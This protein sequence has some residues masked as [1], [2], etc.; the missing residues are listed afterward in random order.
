MSFALLYTNIYKL[1]T[2]SR[3]IQRMGLVINR[4]E[5][6]SIIEKLQQT[7]EKISGE[8]KLLPLQQ[9]NEGYSLFQERFNPTKLKALTGEDL[10]ETVINIGNRNGLTYWLE[11]KNDEEFKTNANSYGSIAGGSAFKYILF[12]RKSDGKWVTGKPQEPTILTIEEAIVVASEI[13]DALVTGAQFIERLADNATEEDYMELQAHMEINLPNMYHLGWV[14]K[15]YHMI[16][17]DKI[18]SFHSANWQ[19]HVLIKAQVMPIQ[20]DKLYTNTGQLM[21][22]A[23]KF[24]MPTTYVMLSLLNLFGGPTNYYRIEVAIADWHDMTN[25]GYVAIRLPNI[26]DLNHFTDKKTIREDLADVFRTHFELDDHSARKTAR[27]M[28]R[29]YHQLKVEDIVIAANKDKIYGIGKVTGEYEFIDGNTYPHRKNVEWLTIFDNPTNLPNAHEGTQAACHAYKDLNNIVG[30]EKLI[31]D[32]PAT[33]LSAKQVLQPLSKVEAEIQIILKRK[34]QVILYGPP[35]TGKTYHA[36]KTCYELSARNLYGKSFTS[37]SEM[38][39]EAIKGDGRTSGTVRMCCFHP[40]YGY[41]DFIEGIKPS[42]VNGQTVFELKDGIFKELCKDAAS[43]PNRNY[44]LIIDEIN[45]GDIARIF[46]ELIMLIESGKRGKQL[47]LSL[48][49]APFTVPENV[50]IVGTMNTADRSI[51]LLDVALRRRFGFIELMTDYRL[52]DGVS[53]EGLPL[54]E[55]LKELNNRIRTHIGGEARNLQIGHSYFLDKEKAV[56]DPEKFKWIIKDDIIPLIEE[57]CYN[58]YVLIEKILGEGIVDVANQEINTTLFSSSD[59]SDLITAL[60]S[61]NPLLRTE[62]ADGEEDDDNE[63][64]EQ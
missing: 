13:R 9:L 64:E 43:N 12:K 55:W 42:V 24:E 39:I 7:Y 58:D 31:D 41:E 38:E 4:T 16:Y 54:G 47:T 36:E 50:F 52:F 5:N 23:R 29:F 18:T 22:I 40:S 28:T 60:L 44:Y 49:N 19:K 3:G 30:I 10:L 53:F 17:P 63:L 61:H 15:Y 57:Y 6:N 46:G 62:A 45:R 26:G 8:N 51:A 2:T 25:N 1:L 11:F 37:L 33:V 32:K 27:E 35:G 14:H 34:K 21:Q 59:T 20:P 56:E 48:S